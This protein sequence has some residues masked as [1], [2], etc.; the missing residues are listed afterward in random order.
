MKHCLYAAVI[1]LLG[2]VS[3][4]AEEPL[5]RPQFHNRPTLWQLFYDIETTIDRAEASGKVSSE[6]IQ[7]YREKL[8]LWR[9]QML[10]SAFVI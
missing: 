9:E 3:L 4:P 10:P 2:T 8:Q 6:V 7:H 1:V 5:P